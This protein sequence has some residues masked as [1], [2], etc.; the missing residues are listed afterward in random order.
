MEIDFENCSFFYFLTNLPF[1]GIFIAI[2]EAY[3]Q[4]HVQSNICSIKSIVLHG[5]FTLMITF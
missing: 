1:L 4:Q 5:Y 2:L 3:I